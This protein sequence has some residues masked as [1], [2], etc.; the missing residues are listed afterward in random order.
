MKKV[1]LLL[2]LVAGAVGAQPVTNTG[3][4]TDLPTLPVA[5][6]QLGTGTPAPLI[7]VGTETAVLVDDGYY[8]IPQQLAGYPTAAVIWPRVVEV[9]CEKV[10]EK[11]VC[12][13]YHWSPRLGRAEYVLLLPRLKAPPPQPPTRCCEKVV[14]PPPVVIYREVP[15]KRKAE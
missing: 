5:R 10:G 9:E 13:G 11:V 3:A 7:T 8:H 14:T 15:V 4:R 2:L 6:N 1:L 12:D